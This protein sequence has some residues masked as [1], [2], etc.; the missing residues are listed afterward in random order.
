MPSDSHIRQSKSQPAA[1]GAKHS[2]AWR[3]EVASRLDRY[4]ARRRRYN[5]D[6]SLRFDFESQR[7]ANRNLVTGSLIAPGTV[8]KPPDS[9]TPII[10]SG[11]P[12]HEIAALFADALQQVSQPSE[13]PSESAQHIEPPSESS[14]VPQDPPQSTPCAAKPRRLR[15]IIEFPRPAA[16]FYYAANELAEPVMQVPRIVEALPTA[17]E[18]LLPIVPAITLD[19]M[20][21]GA[22]AVELELPLCPAPV[23][24]RAIAGLLDCAVVGA[25]LALFGYL[26]LKISAVATLPL[27]SLPHNR[28]AMIAA[29]LTSA[30]FWVGYHYLMIVLGGATTGMR[31]AALVLRTFKGA[32]PDREVRKRR[33]YALVISAVAAGLGFLW[34]FFDEDTLGW[35]DRISKTYLVCR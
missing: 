29:T 21:D 34:A 6:L 32:L 22:P 18:E 19:E 10:E 8:R 9:A 11:P 4:R 13:T 7:Q 12:P 28:A 25:G 20:P 17:E 14:V 2:E 3:D 27:A 33:L 26:L 30:A 31:A 5:P 15:K 16:Q 24:R 23:S 35:H 1:S